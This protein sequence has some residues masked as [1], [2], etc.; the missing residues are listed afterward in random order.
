MITQINLEAEKSVIGSV[1]LDPEKIDKVIWLEPRD[2]QHVPHTLIWTAIRHLYKLDRP[3]DVVS[4]T[5]ELVKYKRLD[6]IGGV[7]Y[8]NE[9]LNQ[10]PT[11]ANVE[12]H[13]GI[14]RE[15]SIRRRVYDIGQKIASL[16]NQPF[17]S[18][19]AMFAEIDRLAGSV[20]PEA[21]GELVHLRDA[22]DEYFDYLDR[23]DD[24]IK[25]GFPQFDSWVGGLG[26][27]WLYVLA[28]RPSVGKTAKMLQMLRGIAAQGQG[29]CL[30]WSQ[31]MKRPALVNRMMAS[32][33]GIELDTFRLKKLDA[34]Q[35]KLAREIYQQEIAPLPI[36]IA[37]AKHVTIDEITAAARQAKREAGPI[38]AIFVD[39]LGI[40]KI[41][42]PAG[43]TRQQAIG[44][45][46]KKAKQLAMELDCVFILLAQMN[47]EGKKAIQP[48]LEH[49]RE[50]GDIEQDADI[51]E[52]LWENPDDTNPGPGA[53]GAKVVQSIIAKG[54][55]VGVNKFRYA[56]YGKY[57][58]FIDL[59]P[60]MEE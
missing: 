46:T 30:V 38:A 33:T 41:P 20:R 14:V 44:E 36:R 48:S 4:I 37:D 18:T 47:R 19:E 6:E 49:L 3:I 50:S 35:K 27:G 24:L 7:G 42:Q 26:R 54:R 25:T 40:M 55:D 23:E 32:I 8:L 60:L 59:P 21:Q 52:F 39:Y 51:V 11:A 22:E 28:A 17:D 5:G 2:F 15:N 29:Q 31:E 43:V 57:Q 34:K 16:S 9:L 53:P 58:Q 10:T 56:F 1:L 45:V 13:A 12:Y